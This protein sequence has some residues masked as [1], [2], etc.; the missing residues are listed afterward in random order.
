MHQYFPF[1]NVQGM[2]SG[3]QKFKDG[4][5]ATELYLQIMDPLEVLDKNIYFQTCIKM[6]MRIS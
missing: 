1:S 4:K 3:Q 6:E 5:K 2:S